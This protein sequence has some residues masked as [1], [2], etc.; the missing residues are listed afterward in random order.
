MKF[1]DEEIEKLDLSNVDDIVQ[2]IIV[3]LCGE[4]HDKQ[5]SESDRRL[6]KD[7]L[8]HAKQKGLNYEQFNELLLL[9]NQVRVGEPFYKFFFEKVENPLPDLKISLNDLEQGVVTFRGFAMLCFGNFRFAYKQLIQKN[10]TE[11][12]KL[13]KP[14]C[15]KFNE[16]LK[17]FEGRPRQMLKIGVIKR[18]ETWYIGYISQKKFEKEYEFLKE[19]ISSDIKEDKVELSSVKEKYDEMEKTIIKVNEK[20]LE[21]TNIYLTWDYMDVYIATSM[22]NKWEFQ[23][24]HDLVKGIFSNSQIK[25]LNLRYFDPTQSKCKNRID[26][27]LV[28]GLML[29]RVLCS[30]Y[31]AQ[32]SDTM[33]K[34]SEL[35]ATLAQGKPVIAYIPTI[36]ID[37]YSEKIKEYPLYYFEHRLLILQAEEIFDDERCINKLEKYEQEFS[38]KI[39]DFQEKLNDYHESEDLFKALSLLEEKEN[40]FKEKCDSFSSMCKILAIAEHYNFERRA[41]TLKKYHPLAIQVDLQSGVANGVLVVR[42]TEECAEL[43]YQ[44]LTNNMEFTIKHTGEEGKG[45]IVLEE[46][47]SRCPF[48][49]VTDDEKLTNSFWNFY[50]TS[51]EILNKI[52]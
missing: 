25:K 29:K 13:L 48:R 20:A 38:E 39:K 31:M 50:L 23:E 7:L 51:D 44:I 49:V 32:E 14:Y 30:I 27:G 16:V 22:R 18:D 37:E 8:N 52:N 3:Y 42:S 34:D 46:R 6:L 26:K 28:E 21:N 47:V 33:G 43:L 19:L 10:K 4:K 24:A 12:E 36:D 41:D 5:L 40:E 45:V 35:A 15:K 9:L 1:K 17:E 11:L 2:L